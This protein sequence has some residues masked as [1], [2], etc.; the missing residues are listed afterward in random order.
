MTT[1]YVPVPATAFEEFT[2]RGFR[3]S[4]EHDE[5]TLVQD[6]ARI[7]GLRL[8]IYTSLSAGAVAA[9]SVGSDAIR[10]ALVAVGRDGRTRGVRSFPRVNR[11][12]SVEAVIGRIKGRVH[13]ARLYAQGE[14]VKCSCGAPAYRDSGRCAVRCGGGS[15]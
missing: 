10:V 2:A 9:R 12:G 14:L 13:D 1:A 11:V 8:V 7:P 4:R 15:R 5:V 6:S 3:L